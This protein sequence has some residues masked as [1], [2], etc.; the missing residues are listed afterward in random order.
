MSKSSIKGCFL[1]SAEFFFQCFL[2]R[3]MCKGHRRGEEKIVFR[4]H[5]LNKVIRKQVCDDLSVCVLNIEF[6]SD[7]IKIK[8]KNLS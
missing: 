3:F 1:Y 5:V 8:I 2:L 7:K 4:L 6:V